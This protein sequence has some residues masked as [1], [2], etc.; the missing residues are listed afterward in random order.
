MRTTNI[1]HQFYLPKALSDELEGLTAQPGASKTSVLSDA[2]AAWLERRGAS[3]LDERFGTR[4][5]RIARAI[6]RVERKLDL[7]TE[8]LGV[9]VHYQVTLTAEHSAFGAEA[10]LGRERFGQLVSLVEQRLSGA[11]RS[12][13]ARVLGDGETTQ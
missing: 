8:L 10:Q 6:D 5:D 1:R 9:F 11:Q 12:V 7:T 2:L 3:E 13:A 4:L